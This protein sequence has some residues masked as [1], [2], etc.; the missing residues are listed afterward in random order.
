MPAKPTNGPVVL[1]ILDGWGHRVATDGNAIA[2]ADT[3]AW[4][5]FPPNI[6]GSRFVA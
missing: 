2:L 5:R 3:P 1:C 4:D 6:T